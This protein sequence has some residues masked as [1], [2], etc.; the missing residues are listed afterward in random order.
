MGVPNHTLPIAEASAREIDIVPTWRYADCYVRSIE[1]MEAS[2]HTPS[3]P[4]ILSIVTH[5]FNGLQ[6]VPE[7]LR[8]ACKARDDTE[9]MVIKVAL[10][11]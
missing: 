8:M 7:A 9:R 11:A 1:I 10:L 3:L 6:Q 2:K 5:R 4:N